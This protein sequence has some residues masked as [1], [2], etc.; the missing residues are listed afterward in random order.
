MTK[1]LLGKL[2][3]AAAILLG[4]WIGVR[5]ALPVLFPFLLGAGLALAAEPMV[6][7]LHRRLGLPRGVATGIGV[8]L[9]FILLIAVL[10]L[11]VALLVR[12]AG[13]LA[14]VLPDLT[15]AARQGMGSLEGWLLSLAQRTP[16]SVRGT[17]TQSVTD[18][19]SD[20]G[21][22]MGRVTEKLLG[23]AAGLLGVITDGT[24]GFAASLLSAFMISAKLPRIRQYW[25]EQLPRLRQ[26]RYLVALKGL[27]SA[28]FGWLTA[29]LK[30]AGVTAAILLAG[31]WI[32]RI[33]H[34]LLWA[35]GVAL[36]DAF[37]VLGTGT[38]LIPWALICL[39]QGQQVRA[40]GLLGVYGVVWLTR[41]VL[42]PKLLGKELGL[43]PLV[44]L[45]SMYSGF[46]LL[47]LGGMLLTPMLA[48]AATRLLRTAEK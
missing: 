7:L 19:F 6:A 40:F 31:F 45:I 1:N 22:M 10:V 47:G 14:G 41:S 29:Q 8:T 21:A 24:L 32:L 27:K 38:V 37:P 28:L 42:E 20:S 25:K 2:L 44:T 39:L 9:G 23:F 13:R 3:T 5:Y 17:L 15:E 26:N 18:T 34:A 48:V 43:D 4:A 36:V 35:F 30:L 16:E 46:K 33:P 12:Q 11:T